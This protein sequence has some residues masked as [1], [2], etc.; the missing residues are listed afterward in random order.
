[1]IDPYYTIVNTYTKSYCK[2][3]IGEVLSSP[4]PRKS[5][6]RP[7]YEDAETILERALTYAKKE[8]DAYQVR[9]ANAANSAVA[10]N[11]EE[12]MNRLEARNFKI[13]FVDIVYAE[14]E[15]L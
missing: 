10:E 13:V 6:I 4:I 8:Y 9:Y 2:F 12:Q 1:M 7:T 14:Q 11:L 5:C 15:M 3:D